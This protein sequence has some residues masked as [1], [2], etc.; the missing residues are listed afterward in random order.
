MSDARLK[1][2]PAGED[3]A[4]ERVNP[5]AERPLGAILD[6][7]LTR[8]DV[9]TSLVLSPVL[10]TFAELV[11]GGLAHAEPAAGGST[12][13]FEELEGRLEKFH[14]VARG[15]DAKV[16]LSWGQ[17]VVSGAPSFDPYAQTPDAQEKQ[18]GYNNDF[19][20]FMPLP[21]GS[22][23]SDHGLLC[24]NHEYASP[25]LMFPR[26]PPSE[27]QPSPEERLLERERDRSKVDVMLAAHGHSVVEIKKTG[28]VWQTVPNGT[29]NRRITTRSTKCRLSGPAAGHDRMKTFEDPDGLWVKGTLNNC[30]GGVTPWGTVV[31]AEENF[32]FYF[33]GKPS[34]SE[35]AN[36]LRYGIKGK[37]RWNFG[38]FFER[39]DVERETSEPNRFGWLVEYDPYDPESVPVKRTALGRWNHEGAAMV[40]NKDGR[41]VVYSGD[42]RVY[43]YIYKFV[44]KN[45]FDAKDLAKNKD[46]LDEGTLYAARFE[47]DGT[48]NW[49]PLVFGQGRLTPAF[50]FHSQADV[51]IE[52]RRAADLMGA[53]PLDRP[54]DV[55]INPVTGRVY[56]SLTNN[57][58]RDI[59]RLDAVNPRYDNRFG[60]IV[61]M[62]PPGE[63]KDADH[64]AD[65]FKWE[66][67]ILAGNPR[68]KKHRAK[69]HPD[70]SKHGWFACPDNLAFDKQGRIWI[71][72]DQ[73]KRQ[74]ETKIGDGLWVCDTVGPGRA[75]TRHFFSGPVGAEICG[76]CLTPDNTTIF[77][78]VQHPGEEK[79]SSFEDPA[80]RW[81][82]FKNGMP[83]RPSVVAIVKKGGG[84]LGS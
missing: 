22:D 64:A 55:D 14:R 2:D 62:I 26:D 77:V 28:D 41:V 19:I 47:D 56:A 57:E 44:T 27:P 18:F 29:Y 67:F 71:A 80:T 83:P 79:G 75:L 13:A 20:A 12:L 35:L 82:D 5:S 38:D 58:S 8:R 78:A 43:E 60:H 69:Y 36:H 65:R 51:V 40:L 1:E 15:Y 23:N 45:A 73:G 70:L 17:G 42:D 10:A 61:E 6:A 50:G 3:L 59:D 72:T 48:L 74:N 46:L 31:I 81:P 49:R 37:P 25:E 4:H 76:P 84:V 66:I 7:R 30:S 53:T 16:L 32:D 33:S 63:G 39:F 54:E 21:R 68:D 34:G 9:L 52:A 11:R 24:V